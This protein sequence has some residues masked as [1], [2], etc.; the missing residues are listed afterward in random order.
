MYLYVVLFVTYFLTFLFLAR[1]MIAKSREGGE[2]TVKKKN[3]VV[4]VKI[5]KGETV[6]IELKTLEDYEREFGK[7]RLVPL[8]DGRSDNYK[9]Y[10]VVFDSTTEKNRFSLG[11]YVA[12]SSLWGE[13]KFVTNEFFF[14]SNYVKIDLKNMDAKFLIVPA[15]S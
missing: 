15:A 10:I 4:P 14:D 7:G 11:E 6:T 1:F 3:N 12:L 13:E 9:G 2:T 8:W 5:E